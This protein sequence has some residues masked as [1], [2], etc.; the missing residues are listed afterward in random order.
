MTRITYA[1][2][3]LLRQVAAHQQIDD[4]H[5]ATFSNLDGFGVYRTL[6]FEDHLAALLAPLEV[7]PRVEK[8]DRASITFVTGRLADDASPFPVAE[9][10]EIV[11]DV[12]IDPDE[13]ERDV[14]EQELKAIPVADLRETYGYD[15]TWSK[16]EIVADVLESEFA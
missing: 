16:K 15:K 1:A 6:T 3:T 4:T 2:R 13:A 8:V 11:E 12:S 5:A 7:D 10:A 14:R 9:V